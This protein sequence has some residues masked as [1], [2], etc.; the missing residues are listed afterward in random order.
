MRSVEY[1]GFPV[2]GVVGRAAMAVLREHS[3]GEPNLL[4]Q[5]TRPTVKSSLSRMMLFFIL[6]IRGRVMLQ[7]IHLFIQYQYLHISIVLIG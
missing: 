2:T 6:T 5:R 4:R 1:S 7:V 3:F